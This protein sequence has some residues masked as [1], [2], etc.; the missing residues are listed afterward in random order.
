MQRRARCRLLGTASSL[1]LLSAAPAP[2]AAAAGAFDACSLLT[3]ADIRAVQNAPVASTKSSQPERD[4]FSVSQCFYTLAPFSKS[5]SLEV[6]R[7]RPGEKEGPREYWKE[8]FAPA[9]WKEKDQENEKE[10]ESERGKEREKSS[11]P[12]RVRGVG[13][14]AYWV[15]PATGG[16]LYV[17]RGDA[18][19][20]LSLGGS[21]PEAVKIRKLARLAGKAVKR[22]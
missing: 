22:L 6:T 14:D 15:G 19:F 3:S 12:R 5:I 10:K 20:R 8:L 9:R 11:A 18:F 7:R 1:L 13:D 2:L 16:G 21:D 17:L 4:R